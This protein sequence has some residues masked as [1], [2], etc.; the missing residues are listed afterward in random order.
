MSATLGDRA[1]REGA[2]EADAAGPRSPCARRERPVPLDFEYRETPLHETIARAR[3]RTGARPSTSS[4]S[5]SARAA[6][7]AQNLMSVDFSPKER[8][9]APSREALGRRALRHALRQGGAALP[10]ATASALHHAGLLPKYRLL[11]EKLAQKGLLAIISGTDTLGVG[12]NI[13]IRTVL[14]TQ[15]CKFDGEKTAHPQRARLP[16]DRGPRGAQ[17][18]RRPRLR[19]RAGARARHREPAPR[20]RRP[21]G[22]PAKL[23]RIVRKKPPDKGYVHWDR[24]TFDRLVTRRSPSR[25]SRASASRTGWSSNVLEPARRRLHARWRASSTARTSDAPQRRIFGRE[26]RDDVP[27]ARRGG[28]RRGRRRARRTPRARPRRPAGGLL[29][30]P[31]AL[32][33]PRRHRSSALDRES[34]T[35]ALDVLTLVESILENPDF[36]LRAAARR[37]QER[38]A[39]RS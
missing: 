7:T 31:R 8:E 16:A 2:D 12:V 4:T 18:L 17:G 35:Y 3:R 29:A 33:L 27:V 28:H 20:G 37:A 1:L 11:V 5:R 36:V 24:A 23:K 15:L 32:A 13:P 6:E 34:P 9:E 14:F 26:A 19:R 39:R 21:R 38:E 10:R 22:D 30:P 25:S